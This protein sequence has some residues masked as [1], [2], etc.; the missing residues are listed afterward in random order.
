MYLYAEERRLFYV[1]LTRTKKRVY[2]LTTNEKP[3]IFI[4]EIKNNRFVEN[5]N[6]CAKVPTPHCP[7]CETGHLA[8]R[9][10]NGKEFVGCTN[11]PYCDFT[12]PTTE[13]LKEATVCPSCNEGF[14]IV[15]EGKYGK[16][17]GCSNYPDCT[18]TQHIEIK[19]DKVTTEQ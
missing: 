14:L 7:R 11:Y 2:I 5:T 16:F 13:V 18:H 8:I 3:S 1:A 15:K 12:C 19:E 9:E 17:Y 10:N 6:F 4:Q